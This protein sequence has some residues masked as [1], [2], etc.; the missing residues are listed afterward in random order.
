[1]RYDINN[2]EKYFIE[3]EKVTKTVGIVFISVGL[4]SSIMGIAAMLCFS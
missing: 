4:V 1:V 3:G 2:P